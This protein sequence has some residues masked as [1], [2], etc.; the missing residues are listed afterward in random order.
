MGGAFTVGQLSL[1]ERIVELVRE[2]P[3]DKDEQ[4]HNEIDRAAKT[5]LRMRVTAPIADVAAMLHALLGRELIALIAGVQSVRTVSQWI[6]GTSE[7]H[8]AHEEHLRN[9]YQVATLLREGG[10][11]ERAIR[12]WFTGMNPLLED[13]PPAR[14]I[15]EH[16]IAV[17]AAAKDY[18]LDQ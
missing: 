12:T 9:A 13:R 10:M 6:Q 1:E 15:Q 18:L 3:L 17:I 16:P 5:A 7:P 14:T 8:P 2:R 4:A 11:S